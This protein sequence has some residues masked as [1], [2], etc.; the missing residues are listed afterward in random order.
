MEYQVSGSTKSHSS[1]IQN[2]SPDGACFLAHDFIPI[3][4]TL[5]LIFSY[6]RYSYG[7]FAKV[8][9]VRQDIDNKYKVGVKF[10]NDPKLPENL[11]GLKEIRRFKTALKVV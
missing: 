2:I 1:V 5:K 7:G 11:I 3:G 6:E 4:S 8:I 9:W 10:I